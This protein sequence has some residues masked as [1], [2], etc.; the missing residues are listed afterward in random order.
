MHSNLVSSE[1]KPVHKSLR[2][3]KEGELGEGGGDRTH[4]KGWMDEW[5]DK[6]RRQE[7]GKIGE[8]AYKTLRR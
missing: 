6:S 7:E 2:W 3:A 4:Y 5:G 8:S 1:T